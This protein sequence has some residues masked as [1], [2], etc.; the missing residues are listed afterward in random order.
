MI[1]D[2]E[3]LEAAVRCY[4]EDSIITQCIRRGVAP[5]SGDLAD[6]VRK[7]VER[8]YAQKS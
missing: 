5:H 7:A 1:D 4:G 2:S 8:E 6:E 3:A